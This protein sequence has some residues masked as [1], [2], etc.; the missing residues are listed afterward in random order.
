MEITKEGIKNYIEEYGIIEALKGFAEVID[1]RSYYNVK[2]Y[3]VNR[4]KLNIV[5]PAVA[6]INDNDDLIVDAFYKSID[7]KERQ[8][9]PKIERMSNT[10]IEKL[11]EK[12]EKLIVKG[13][14]E[15]SLRYAKELILRDEKRFYKLITKLALFDAVDLKKALLVLSLKKIN[16]KD[17]EFIFL[18]MSY[19]NKA[20]SDY[21]EYEKVLEK[22]KKE[23]I[24]YLDYNQGKLNLLFENIEILLK[25][26]LLEN[27]MGLNIVSYLC[28]MIEME[29]E[30][31]I[32][33]EIIN[34]KIKE[35]KNSLEKTNKL[36]DC[37][38][39]ILK[40]LLL[41]LKR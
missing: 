32:F 8:I 16:K 34:Q 9:I 37:E 23:N 19:I 1:K 35:L 2:G 18:L 28:L 4:K 30:K 15:F 27:C 38:K 12:L 29:E 7:C 40:K 17:D 41:I 11:E 3:E 5:L 20:K 24:N 33:I 39:E 36:D 31:E 26:G 21:S 6:F 10:T 22:M 25:N 14:F 13:S